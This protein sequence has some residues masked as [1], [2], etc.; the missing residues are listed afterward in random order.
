MS[1]ET[2][3]V[4]EESRESGGLWSRAVG[5]LRGQKTAYVAPRGV[6]IYAVGD[7]HGCRAE[8]TRLLANIRDDA[9]GFT[10]ARELIFLG[11]YVDRGPDSKGT[12]ELLLKPPAGFRVQYLRGNHDQAVLDF[13]SDPGFFR[14]WREFGARETLLSYGVRPPRFED[15]AAF[16]EARD[17]LRSAM[18][19]TH[20][21]FLTQLPLSAKIGGYYFAHAGVRPGVKLDSQSAEDLLWIRD[22]FLMSDNDLGAIVV[23]GHTPT[24]SPVRRANRIGVDTGCYATG[25]LTAAVLEGAAC[26]FIQC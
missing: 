3:E 18:P 8:L 20:L 23:H 17:E 5:L 2:L 24:D 10:G 11:D 13:L 14:T 22:A 4:D 26:R 25:K 9:N 15:E 1:H 6:R 7:I 19:E 16:M 21:N 12:I